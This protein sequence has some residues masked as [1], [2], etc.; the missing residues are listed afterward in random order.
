VNE[1]QRPKTPGVTVARIVRAHGRRGEVAAEILTDFPER[2]TRLRCALLS[3]G[4][5]AFPAAE[6]RAVRIQNCRLSPSRGGQAIF[7]F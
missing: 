3:D 7:H 1:Q 5:T 2:L 4:R 6:P